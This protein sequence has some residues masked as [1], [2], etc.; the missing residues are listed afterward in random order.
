MAH[1]I[2]KRSGL[3]AY[4]PKQPPQ[5]PD[6]KPYVMHYR[7][8]LFVCNRL[9]GFANYSLA[10]QQ[11][12]SVWTLTGASTSFALGSREQMEAI[13]ALLDRLL[14]TERPRGA[15]L[16]SKAAEF[17]G[18]FNKICADLDSAIAAHRSH[19][20]CDLVPFF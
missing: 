6:P 3:E 11:Q 15:E 18:E 7:L 1:E 13:I 14:E 20:R 12:S 19:G 2:L 10:V 17:H 9:A 16:C 8:A 4:P 5:G